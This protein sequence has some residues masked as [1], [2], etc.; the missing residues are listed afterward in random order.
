MKTRFVLLVALLLAL[1]LFASG[2]TISSQANGPDASAAFVYISESSFSYQGYLE[3]EG[4]P[5]DGACDFHFSLWNASQG[6]EQ[7][8]PVE[9]IGN[10][11]VREGYFHVFLDFGKEPFSEN[12]QWLETEVRCPA[13]SGAYTLLGDRQIILQ[14]PKAIWAQ[15]MN[16]KGL[17]ETPAGFAD[18]VDDDTTYD[19]GAGLNLNGTRFS[20]DKSWFDGRYQSRPSRVVVV[21]QKGGDFNAI[22]AAIDSITDANA[23]NPYLVWVAPGSYQEE[24]TL[25]PYVILEGAGERATTISAQVASSSLPITQ[26]TLRVV[27]YSEVRE[28]TVLNT[29]SGDH[30]AALLVVS[31]AEEI[32]IRRVTAGCKGGEQSCHGI[33]LNGATNVRLEDVTATAAV[34]HGNSVGLGLFNGGQIQLQGGDYSAWGGAE[35]HGIVNQGEM[36]AAEI[37][38]SANNAS[39]LN[40]AYYQDG[41][42]GDVQGELLG[43]TFTARDGQYADGIYVRKNDAA[44]YAEDVVAVGKNALY[45]NTGLDCD[46]VRVTLVGGSFTGEKGETAAGIRCSISSLEARDVKAEGVDG[47]IHS[48]GLALDG[49]DSTLYAGVFLARGALLAQSETGDAIVP[50][51]GPEPDPK[52]VGLVLTGDITTRL[53]THD[54]TAMGR[55]ADIN[56][57]LETRGDGLIL[58]YGGL[59]KGLDYSV[60]RQGSDLTL[61]HTRLEG[62]EV[63][64]ACVRCVLVSRG[65]TVSTDGH[66]CP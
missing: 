30:K 32:T 37:N 3:K 19:A 48:Y 42:G 17:Q 9:Q 31:E 41:Y 39:L 22:Q 65:T 10:V 27:D 4:D 56:V 14:A 34:A 45:R 21:A 33:Y 15:R 6:G 53:E 64:D 63:F 44:L 49:G 13:G 36:R 29:G 61:M 47:R 2:G 5:Y 35:A 7:I 54:V 11:T 26:A 24:V 46:D 57:G 58:F 60:K 28:L 16:W 66:T 59:L 20:A 50:T 23:K 52:A 62:G 55:G 25:K 51:G 43:G 18:G 1:T 40:S 8:A 12:H 38:A